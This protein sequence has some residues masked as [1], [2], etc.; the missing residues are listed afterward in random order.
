MA[1]N[2]DI[3]YDPNVL[4]NPSI[5]L[6]TQ[7]VTNKEIAQNKISDGKLRIICYGINQDII[8][9]GAIADISFKVKTTAVIGTTQVSISDVVVANA[10]ASAIVSTKTDN[11]VT[12]QQ[13]S[14]QP[15]QFVNITIVNN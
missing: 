10:N 11:S 3:N 13:N 1:F 9:Q 7:L 4:E 12:I 14:L 8:S 2:L 5:V 15:P 6:N